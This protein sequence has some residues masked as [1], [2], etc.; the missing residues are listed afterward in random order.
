MQDAALRQ[1]LDRHYAAYNRRQFVHPD[2]GGTV[3]VEDE[4]ILSRA[5]QSGLDTEVGQG[6]TA[7]PDDV[8]TGSQNASAR[9]V[10][11]HR[12]AHGPGTVTRV[13]L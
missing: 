3:V 9:G 12:R 7:F 5:E 11:F 2:Q 10:E 13:D 4:K 8:Y 6:I 1:V